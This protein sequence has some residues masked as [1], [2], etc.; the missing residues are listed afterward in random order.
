MAGK[1]HGKDLPIGCRRGNNADHRCHERQHTIPNPMLAAL[2]LLEQPEVPRHCA[3]RQTEWANGRVRTEER[4]KHKARNQKTM[5]APASRQREK[6]VRQKTGV[7]QPPVAKMPPTPVAKHPQ[8][9]AALPAGERHEQH[10]QQ[11]RH[12]RANR[13]IQRGDTPHVKIPRR[14]IPSQRT[15]GHGDEPRKPR[16]SRRHPP[17]QTTKQTGKNK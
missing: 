16:H 1:R 15:L 13:Q 6:S 11:S 2:Q 12:S 5:H 3:E 9:T 17:G 4:Q 14:A 7:G 10:N 8:R